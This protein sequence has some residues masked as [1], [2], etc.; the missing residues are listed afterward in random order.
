MKDINPKHYTSGGIEPIDFIESHK[1]GF[2][3]GSVIKYLVR[4]DRKGVPVED[5]V[6]IFNYLWREMTGTWMPEEYANH[7][8][9]LA[10]QKL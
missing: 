10:K 3:A 9:E 2:G 4:K 8:R 7:L 6:K 5:T 1:M